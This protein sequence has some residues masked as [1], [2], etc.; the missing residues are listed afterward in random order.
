MKTVLDESRT[1]FFD[2][3]THGL[4]GSLSIDLVEGIK[5]TEPEMVDFGTGTPMGPYYSIKVLRQSK[6]A[7]VQFPDSYL[8]FVYNESFDVG[9]DELEA[10]EGVIKKVAC[11]S[12]I[13]FIQAHTGITSIKGVDFETYLLW[14]EDRLFHVASS[15]QPIV[16]LIDRVP[17]LAVGRTNTW[18]AT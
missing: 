7:R 14:T 5:A 1:W 13:S 17:D 12:F 16:T 11:S 15:G 2:G 4:D 6:C 18:S 8:F 9:N 3:L 10:D